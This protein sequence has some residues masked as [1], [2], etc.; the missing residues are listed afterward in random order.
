MNKMSHTINDILNLHLH[1]F[2]KAQLYS[3]GC[4]VYTT[5]RKGDETGSWKLG[6]WLTEKMLV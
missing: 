5:R 6:N 1:L 4:F 3:S 2:K